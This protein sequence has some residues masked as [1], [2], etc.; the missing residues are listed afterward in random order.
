MLG[1]AGWKVQFGDDLKQSPAGS[2]AVFLHQQ[3]DGLVL[4]DKQQGGDGGSEPGEACTILWL[5]WKQGELVALSSY[6]MGKCDPGT[7]FFTH[8][9]SGCKL[10]SIAGGP[11]FHI[12]SPVAVKDFVPHI[13]KVEEIEDMGGLKGQSCAYIYSLT[14]KPE[15]FDLTAYRESEWEKQATTYG[16]AGTVGECRVGGVL[17]QTDGGSKYIDLRLYQAIQQKDSWK[18]IKYATWG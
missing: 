13:Q 1:N 10:L 4:I 15:E 18:A 9:F 2:Q 17:S 6:S 3:A 11:V 8:D 5:P 7:L 12:D 16:M 14:S